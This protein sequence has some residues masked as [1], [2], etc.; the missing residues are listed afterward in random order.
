MQPS[1]CSLR[2]TKPSKNQPAY[3]SWASKDRDTCKQRPKWWKRHS[4]WDS[5]RGVCQPG[6]S[7]ACMFLIHLQLVIAVVLGSMGHMG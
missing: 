5:Y 2:M 7:V 6:A 3:L 1:T 4:V